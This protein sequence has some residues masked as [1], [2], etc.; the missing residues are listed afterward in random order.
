MQ[1]RLYP[2][3]SELFDVPIIRAYQ[4]GKEPPKPFATYALRWENQPEHFCY[5]QQGGGK[6]TTH[7]ESTL[8][9]QLFADRA[10]ELLKRSVLRLKLQSMLT[11]WAE[12]D[13]AIV[14]IG[15]V[16]D[17]P[18]LNEAQSYDNRAIVEIRLRYSESLDDPT[19]FFNQVEVE[20]LDNHQTTR[21][22][23]QDGEN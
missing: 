11:K 7:L 2:L 5:T 15:K 13:I 14:E 19:E 10:F 1:D 23:V 18:F 3:L 6:V 8:E 9:L 4:D 20:N 12:S 16:S 22:G 17:M 21:I